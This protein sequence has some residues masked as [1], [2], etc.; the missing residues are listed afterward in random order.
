MTAPRRILVVNPLWPHSAHSVRAANVVVFELIAELARQAKLQIGFLKI[1]LAGTETPTLI[2]EKGRQELVALGVEFLPPFIYSVES[3]TRPRLARWLAPQEA[4]FYPEARYRI[5]ATAAAMG[6]RPDLVFIPWSERATALFADLPVKKFAYYGNPDPKAG[7]ARAA[8]AREHGGSSIAYARERWALSRLERVHLGI[9]RRFDYLGDV[10]ANDAIY[11]YNHGHP[12]AFYIR[13]LWIDRLGT[14]W[15]VQR[16]RERTDPFVIVGNLGQ[17]G[18]TAN[19]HGLEILARDVLPELRRAM[20]SHKFEIHIFGAGVPHPAV[21]ALLSAPEIRLRGFVDDIDCELMT[22]PVFLCL[23]NASR[24]KVGHTRYLH[25]WSLGGCIV[26]HR[27]AALSMPEMISGRNCL[28]GGSASQI[29]DHVVMA[30][31][32]VLLRR[33]LSEAGYATFL[34]KFTA[35]TVV[36]EILSRIGHD[37]NAAVSA[38]QKLVG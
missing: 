14:R 31:R 16:E 7:R 29:A 23:N 3:R 12:N 8:F 25:A 32:D 27:D 18:G 38:R 13:N 2:E 37:P 21:A 36:S 1:S 4:D 33:R 20:E 15:R 28:L 35:S 5:A 9:M 22:A 6:F 24:Y 10:A 34:E 11:Y 26:G 30:A 19:T 17:L